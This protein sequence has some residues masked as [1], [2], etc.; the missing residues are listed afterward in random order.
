M[1]I[2]D[3]AISRLRKLDADVPIQQEGGL[4]WVAMYGSRGLSRIDARIDA[5]KYASWASIPSSDEMDTLRR[6]R[7]NRHVV[8]I[9]AGK[10]ALRDL[11]DAYI[12]FKEELNRWI[13]IMRNRTDIGQVTFDEYFKNIRD[14]PQQYYKLR[15]SGRL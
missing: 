10:Q 8:W 14:D 4:D 13:H 9:N 2:Y 12:P 6:G 7:Q 11:R 1:E 5:T 15:E 3:V